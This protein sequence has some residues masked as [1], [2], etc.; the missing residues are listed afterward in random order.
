MIAEFA[1]SENKDAS[2]ADLYIRTYYSAIDVDLEDYTKSLTSDGRNELCA[3]MANKI[4]ADMSIDSLKME[5]NGYM[6]Y[7]LINEYPSSYVLTEYEKYVSLSESNY[8]EDWKNF[9]AD[10]KQEIAEK[11][12]GAKSP[13][14]VKKSIENAVILTALDAT[15]W[16]GQRNKLEHYKKNLSLD[17]TAADSLDAEYQ[18]NLYVEF[19]D[20]IS[21][22]RVTDISQNVFT[23]K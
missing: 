13:E 11:V 9:D 3:A 12:S 7:L 20:M 10:T 23:R 14:D 15:V 5:I 21:S 22:A 6:A 4:T 8:Y 1:N 2:A 17:L 18:K 19:K 16:S